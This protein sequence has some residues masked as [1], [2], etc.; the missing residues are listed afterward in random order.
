MRVRFIH[1][2]VTLILVLAYLLSSQAWAKSA[3]DQLIYLY[4]SPGT[5]QY[6]KANE[7]SY[8]ALL[9]RWRK[10]LKKYGKSSKEIGRDQLL[11]GLEP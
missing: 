2:R 4:L 11:A 10:Y 7:F 9:G 5:A 1:L 6:L 8:D 3:S